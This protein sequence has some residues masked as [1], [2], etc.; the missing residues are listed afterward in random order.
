[1]KKPK[2][3]NFIGTCDTCIYKKEGVVF[4][5][6]PPRVYCEKCDKYCCLDETC[7]EYIRNAISYG[8]NRNL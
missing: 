8:S 6:L 1:M 5:S 7:K 4:T 2:I 3:K